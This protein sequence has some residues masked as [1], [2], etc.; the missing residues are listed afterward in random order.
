MRKN[1]KQKV[2]GGSERIVTDKRLTRGRSHTHTHTHIDINR[3]K[4]RYI[5]MHKH[6]CMYVF[7]QIHTFTQTNTCA[8]QIFPHEI[9]T[10]LNT[11]NNF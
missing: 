11:D 1:K 10:F 7:T 5:Y 6:V 9:Y 8:N 3:H 4:H 2:H